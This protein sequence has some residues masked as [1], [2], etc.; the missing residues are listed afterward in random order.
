MKQ[1]QCLFTPPSW[2]S[3]VLKQNFNGCSISEKKDKNLLLKG[4]VLGET[5]GTTHHLDVV[6]VCLGLYNKNTID[7]MAYTADIYFSQLQSLGR[8]RSRYTQIQF[9]VRI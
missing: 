3:S 7:W 1:A 8:P 9:L 5:L 2:I 4:D 6:S